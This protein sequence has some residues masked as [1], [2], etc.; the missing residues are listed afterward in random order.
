M[1]ESVA[2]EAL[3][4]A[5]EQRSVDPEVHKKTSEYREHSRNSLCSK[6][7]TGEE[8]SRKTVHQMF[9]RDVHLRNSENREHPQNSWAKEAGLD[10]ASLKATVGT[11]VSQSSTGNSDFQEHSQN[12]LLSDQTKVNAGDVNVLLS[13]QD[14]QCLAIT[15]EF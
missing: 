6:K 1:L 4:Q 14:S 2:G 10:I 15:S 9:D 7:V 11:K 5:S 13:V 12:W 8:M 3:Q